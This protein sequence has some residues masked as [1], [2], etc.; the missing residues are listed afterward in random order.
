M[1]LLQKEGFDLTP[2]T[3]KTILSR[4]YAYKLYKNCGVTTLKGC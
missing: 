1:G 2:D 3:P 4:N